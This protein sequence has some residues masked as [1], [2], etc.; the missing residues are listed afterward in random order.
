MSFVTG[1]ANFTTDKASSSEELSKP[2]NQQMNQNT[3]FSMLDLFM[4]LL[5]Y[6]NLWE[7]CH[8]CPLLFKFK[9]YINYSLNCHYSFLYYS[10]K[11]FRTYILTRIHNPLKQ[12][13]LDF[14]D[15]SITDVSSLI[16]VHTLN[17]S[18]CHDITDVSP[19]IH[20]H[21]L[22]LSFCHSIIDVSPLIHVHTLVLIGC[23]GIT[24]FSS[25]GNIRNLSLR[26]CNITDVCALGNIDT[27]DL[28]SCHNITDISPLT[29]VRV[30]DLSGCINIG[31]LTS[32]FVEKTI[33][34]FFDIV[35][36]DYIE[37]RKKYFRFAM[38]Y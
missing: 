30:L 1:M 21:T 19:L 11:A 34:G 12:L 7:Y 31:R 32:N 14:S 36:P 2:T 26:G 33:V 18:F 5:E 15:F 10:D 35:D 28:S 9:K 37:F 17:L 27:L 8:T 16:H 29:N 25:L 23:Y 4:I 24:N 6:T 38:M 13:H 22:N 20:V 3:V